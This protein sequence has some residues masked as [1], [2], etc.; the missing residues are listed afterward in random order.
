MQNLNPSNGTVWYVVYWRSFG[1]SEQNWVTVPLANY[2]CLW[3]LVSSPIKWEQWSYQPQK[4]VEDWS[5]CRGPGTAWKDL[6]L[7][8]SFTPQ[9]AWAHQATSCLHPAFTQVSDLGCPLPASATGSYLHPRVC[10][11]NT[12]LDHPPRME[13]HISLFCNYSL[14][15]LREL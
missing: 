8:P 12:Y 11:T 13:R 2:F 4:A 7:R 1:R 9:V 5:P 15:R 3:A 10:L 6:A 14:R